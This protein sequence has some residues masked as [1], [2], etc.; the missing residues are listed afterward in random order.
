[1]NRPAYD[2]ALPIARREVNNLLASGDVVLESL[3]NVAD[4]FAGLDGDGAINAVV[5]VRSGLAAAIDELVLLT[6]EIAIVTDSGGE[7]TELR[8]GDGDTAGGKLMAA[9]QIVVDKASNE[10]RTSTTAAAIDGELTVTG[11]QAGAYYEWQLVAVGTSTA[12]GLKAQ[13]QC[14]ST[15][16]PEL[17]FG[18]Y[19][20]SGVQ[21]YNL[22]GILSLPAN[23]GIGTLRIRGSGIVQIPTGA[24]DISLYWAQS[25]SD[26]STTR[27]NAG[28]RLIVRRV[29]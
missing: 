21:A 23:V 17:L 11:L 3:R 19:I 14:G 12:G 20:V 13:I 5:Q 29:A 6:G 7:A 10:T 15:I 2:N 18:Q 25:V 1:M 24:S 27:I 22:G 9:S 28:S 8:I 4:G 16:M 26:A